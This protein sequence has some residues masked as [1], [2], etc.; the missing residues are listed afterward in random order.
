MSDPRTPQQSADNLSRS[1]DEN[2]AALGRVQKRYRL[3]VAL[4]VAVALTL[5]IAIKFNYDG[6]VQRCESGNELRADIDYKFDSITEYLE[7]LGVGDEPDEV[8]FLE[9]LSGDLEQRDCSE[10]NWLGR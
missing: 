6:N 3:V 10:I 2:T 1:L 7:T 5:G 9:L 8:A 4:I